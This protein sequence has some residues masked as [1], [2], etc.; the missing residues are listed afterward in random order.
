MVFER[1]LGFL[2]GIIVN[3]AI[4]LTF[5]NH[6]KLTKIPLK[7]HSNRGSKLWL[8]PNPIKKLIKRLSVFHGG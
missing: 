8:Q 1:F 6:G 2:I 5:S 4:F 3:Y 7:V